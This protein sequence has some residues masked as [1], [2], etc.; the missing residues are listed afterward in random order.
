MTKIFSL[1]T[2][3]SLTALPVIS[4]NAQ[5]QTM[6]GTR[7]GGGKSAPPPVARPA[8]PVAPLRTGGVFSPAGTWQVSWGL[9]ETL[10][11]DE[12][13]NVAHGSGNA[14]GVC[15]RVSEGKYRIT[16]QTGI[17]GAD[18][19]WTNFYWILASNGLLTREDGKGV[20]KRVSTPANN[21][22]SVA[23]PPVTVPAPTVAAANPPPAAT[24]PSVATT[25]PGA[26]PKIVAVPVTGTEAKYNEVLA[27]LNADLAKERARVLARTKTTVEGIANKYAN[28]QFGSKRAGDLRDAL[29][30][31]ERGAPLKVHKEWKREEALVKGLY[32]A[33]IERDKS[34]F[35]SYA[36]M[37]NRYKSSLENLARQ[38][39]R[40][41]DTVLA[42]LIARKTEEVTLSGPRY[43]IVG[44][45]REEGSPEK[46]V[47]IHEDGKVSHFD[48]AK[49][50]GWE[51]LEKEHFKIG[52]DDWWG[53]YWNDF[54]W[55]LSPDGKRLQRY[56][57]TIK[58]NGT[59]VRF[60]P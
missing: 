9:H 17:N 18:A 2:L 21:S 14:F 47:V 12:R 24:S 49:D 40:E 46:V 11:I 5:Q 7:E 43:A 50:G 60:T 51:F 31:V 35:A 38:A 29:N 25:P 3:L 36:A 44:F 41:G 27:K 22:P 26:A 15:Y 58:F 16:R 10:T 4:A 20:L 6:F 1:L 37:S 23:P 8:Q 52:R 48:G 34:I 53:G 42:E 32:N 28:S 19:E 57:G 30:A 56:Q 59:L 45:W 39:L 54:T 33:K 13:G 55:R